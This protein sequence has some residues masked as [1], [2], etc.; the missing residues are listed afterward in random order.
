MRIHNGVILEKRVEMLR[1]VESGQP[2]CG[3]MIVA[4]LTQHDQP[5]APPILY[6]TLWLE[7]YGRRVGVTEEPAR[8][9]QAR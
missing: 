1:R 2:A 8:E 3:R 4:P 5:R 7:S 9:M 6:P